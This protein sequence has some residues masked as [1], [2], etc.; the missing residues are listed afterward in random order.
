MPTSTNA[1]IQKEHT[2][3][4]LTPKAQPTWQDYV[5]HV[6]QILVPGL[7][8]SGSKLNYTYLKLFSL[9]TS[10]YRQMREADSLQC[11]QRMSVWVQVWKKEME[12]VARKVQRL[13]YELHDFEAPAVDRGS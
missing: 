1:E 11:T 10:L 7:S 5:H 12:D 4:S 13:I 9:Q 2:T 6:H 3:Q 8:R